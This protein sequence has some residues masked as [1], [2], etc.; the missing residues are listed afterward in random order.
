MEMAMLK[1]M[2]LF[3]LPLCLAACVHQSVVPGH[4]DVE[5]AKAAYSRGEYANAYS[6]FKPLAEQGNPDAECYLGVMYN[7][8]EGVRTNFYKA[9]KWL[10]KAAEQG[11]ASAQTL[12]G[13]EYFFGQGVQRDYRE[14][15]KWYRR[16]AEQGHPTAQKYLADMYAKG[17]GV[18]QNNAEATKWYRKA[19]EQGYAPARNALDTALNTG[20]SKQ[21]IKIS[22]ENHDGIYELPAR[23]NGVLTLKFILDTG[24]S[25]VNI[26]ADVALT[27]L[28]TGTITESDFLPG[29]VYRLAD[30]SL[31]R[32][33]RLTI[34]KIEI[35]GITINNVPASVGT[36]S[37]SLLLGQSFLSKIGTWSLDNKRHLLLIEEETTK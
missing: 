35:G 5:S 19:A 33:S 4:S 15:L 37:S 1:R 12:M 2:L 17:L 26:P 31:I 30:G 22:L 21:K 29:T 9:V 6:V 36:A 34:R 25:D 16:A 11:N 24:A 18:T 14:A 8:G 10:R 13:N 20:I 7:N 32:S 23:I 3:I 28:R 27:L